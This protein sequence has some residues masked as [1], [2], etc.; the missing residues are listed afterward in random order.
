MNFG[1]GHQSA[2]DLDEI[3]DQQFKTENIQTQKQKNQ[4][5]LNEKK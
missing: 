5:I 2:I 3:G 1:S 4:K